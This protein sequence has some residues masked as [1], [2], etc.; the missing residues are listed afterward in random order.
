MATV[1]QQY[2]DGLIVLSN[3][4]CFCNNLV[5]SSRRFSDHLRWAASRGQFPNPCFFAAA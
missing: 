2:S 5:S 1:L 3:E 4:P